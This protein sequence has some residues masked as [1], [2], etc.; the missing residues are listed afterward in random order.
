MILSWETARLTLSNCYPVFSGLSQM[1]FIILGNR[2]ITKNN[3]VEEVFE[4][5]SFEYFLYIDIKNI[6]QN[7]SIK[8]DIKNLSIKENQKYCTKIFEEKMI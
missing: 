1:K 6:Y 7:I 8:I 3:F 2:F 4:I 5:K